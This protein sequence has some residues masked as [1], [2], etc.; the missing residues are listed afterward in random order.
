[1]C[2]FA[3]SGGLF[4]G[5]DSGGGGTS[6]TTQ[7]IPE[8]LKEYVIFG[9]DEAKTLY[10]GSG[11]EYYPGQT[12]LDPSQD[13]LSAYGNIQ[14]RATAGSP[15]LQG[16]QS[17][18]QKVLSGD[19]LSAGN[20]Y[21]SAALREGADISTKQFFDS[22][23]GGRSAAIMGG[24]M[25]SGAQQDI[26]SRAEQNLASALTNQAGKLA[27]Q[28]YSDERARQEAA[29]GL[30]PLLASADYLDLQQQLDAAKG[31]ESYDQAALEGDIAR[32]NYEQQKPYEKLS[33]FLGAVYGAPVPIQSTTTQ[34]TSGGGKIVC[35]MMNEIYGFGKFRNNI[36][37]AYSESMPNAKSIEKGY[38][39]IFLPLV[40]FA[41]KDGK[42][43]KVVRKILEHIARRRTV[44]I[45]Q[46][47]R[48]K[49]RDK[50][51]MFYRKTLEPLA[52]IVGRIQG[53]K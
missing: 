5:G 50:L 10:Q 28:N 46:E 12:Y 8:W 11:P 31:L 6:Q 17:Q 33:A 34:E 24:R 29:A 51:G 14:N 13:I 25:G 20:P 48:G 38:H 9:L 42:I 41:K 30:A 37:L 52:Y 16:A 45:W 36:W 3:G 23:K 49:K 47:M 15:L 18:Q 21:L 43:N 26:E 2:T 7:D 4:G 1:M 22:L 53:V 39:T 44:A 32:F 35:S 27:Y 19:Y 40:N